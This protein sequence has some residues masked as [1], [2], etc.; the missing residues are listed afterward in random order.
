MNQTGNLVEIVIMKETAIDLEWVRNVYPLYLHDLS[1][2]DNSY[3]HLN[4]H[5]CWEPDHL[6]SWLV[7]DYSFPHLIKWNTQKVGFAF[8]AKSPFPYMSSGVDYR[9]AEFFVLRSFRRIGIGR[10][11]AHTIFDL[12]TGTWEV[13]ELP[14]NNRALLFWR[15]VISEHTNGNFIQTTQEGLT[16][17][18]FQTGE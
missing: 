11:A 5:G 10:A 17:Q 6:S 4:E 9:M 14:R 2:Y 15:A 8:V 12:Y 18:V 16:R 1:E 13:T 7:H 3:Y